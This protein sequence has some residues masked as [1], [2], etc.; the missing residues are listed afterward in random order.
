MTRNQVVNGQVQIKRGRLQPLWC[1]DPVGICPI[2]PPLPVLGACCRFETT[3]LCGTGISALEGRA[4]HGQ[5]CP[6]AVLH[7]K[8]GG[9]L[10]DEQ[11]L[12]VFNGLAV[13]DQ[14]FLDGA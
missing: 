6:A 14:N 7:T 3:C 13:V 8:A 4:G 11:G 9:L 10:D 5:G 12:A 1:Q 2:L